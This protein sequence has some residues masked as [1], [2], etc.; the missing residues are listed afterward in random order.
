MSKWVEHS[1]SILW[2]G[3]DLLACLLAPVGRAAAVHLKRLAVQRKQQV[4][5]AG[6]SQAEQS[7]VVVAC[8]E[9]QDRQVGYRRVRNAP[10]V[11]FHPRLVRGFA[12]TGCPSPWWLVQL[13]RQPGYQE[14]ERASDCLLLHGLPLGRWLHMS[15]IWQLP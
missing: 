9:W 3:D 7:N 1:T 14:W 11:F 13:R 6:A 4:C 10:R 5:I 8:T 2:R 12:R 15:L